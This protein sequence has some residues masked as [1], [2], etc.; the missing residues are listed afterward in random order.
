MME[1]VTKI[2]FISSDGQ[3][4][5]SE[6]KCINHENKKYWENR[7]YTECRHADESDI[8]D[9]ILKNTSGFIEVDNGL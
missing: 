8:Y 9:W 6:Q 1:K 4:F 7:I 2:V 5:D 3:E